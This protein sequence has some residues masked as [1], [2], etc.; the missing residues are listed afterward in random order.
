MF[1]SV[2]MRRALVK[3]KALANNGLV[4]I[5]LFFSVY[6]CWAQTSIQMEETP[7]KKK[8]GVLML[9][10]IP[11]PIAYSTDPDEKVDSLGLIEGRIVYDADIPYLLLYKKEDIKWADISLHN[12]SGYFLDQ[13]F[14][15]E[16]PPDCTQIKVNLKDKNLEG[17]SCFIRVKLDDRTRFFSILTR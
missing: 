16:L 11:A 2:F 9:C 1:L 4:I 7:N 15:S 3:K 6:P 12:S 17:K 10:N 8:A 5:C 13:I 14:L